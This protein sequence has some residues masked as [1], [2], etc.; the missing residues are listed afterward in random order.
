MRATPLAVA[1]IL[2]LQP[3][4]VAAQECMLTELPPL[5]TRLSPDQAAI[6][7]LIERFRAASFLVDSADVAEIRA[8]SVARTDI[9]APD[10]LRLEWQ[11]GIPAG[12]AEAINLRRCARRDVRWDGS[13][14]LPL[15]LRIHERLGHVPARGA[16]LQQAGRPLAHGVGD[17]V[18]AL[19]LELRV[20]GFR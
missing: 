18:S 16:R 9:M 2:L 4:G 10:Y 8:D 20:I 13:R 11:R 15:A 14:D 1:A 12:P 19:R 6:T 7:D 17:R 3:R 5:Q